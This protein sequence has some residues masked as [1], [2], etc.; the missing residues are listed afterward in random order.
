MIAQNARVANRRADPARQAFVVA[1]AFFCQWA[2]WPATAALPPVEFSAASVEIG[3][4]RATGLEVRLE[5][6]RELEARADQWRH[7]AIDRVFAAVALDGRLVDGQPPWKA[8]G[9]SGRVRTEGHEADLTLRRQEGGVEAELVIDMLP[10]ASLADI[11]GSTDLAGW[12]TRG[13][14]SARLRYAGKAERESA[15]TGTLRIGDL[16]FDSPDG[17]FAAEGLDFVVEG[18]WA[19]SDAPGADLRGTLA[20]G[21]L[22]IDSFYRDFSDGTLDFALQPRWRQGNLSLENIRLTDRQFLQ[23]RGRARIPSGGDLQNASITVDRLELAFPGAYLR[24][25][26]PAAATW[27]LD[28]LSV[29]GGMVWSGSWNAGVFRSGDLELRDLSVVDTTANRFA[30]TGLE[31][32]LRPGDHRFDSKLAW[33]GLLFGRI[34]LGAG[35]VAL[36][37]EPGAVA[38]RRPLELDVLGG[39]LR[40]QDFRIVFPGRSEDLE[41]EPDIRLRVGLEALDMKRLTAAMDWPSFEGK[42]SGEIPG[43]RFQDGVLEVDGGIRVNVFDGRIDLQ[44]LRIERPFGVLP[45][46]AGT[47]EIQDLD[48]EQLTRTF[49]FGRIAGRLDGHVHELRMLDWRPVAF[50]AWLGTPE[51]Q[52]EKNDI[53]RQAVNRLT[54][55]GGGGAT[56]A[57]TSPILRLFNSFSYRRLGLGCRLRNDVCEVRGIGEDD[58]SVLLLEGAGIPKITIRAFNRRVDWPQMVANLLA[59]STDSPETPGN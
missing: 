1:L 6:G 20:S 4:L 49:S 45:S 56:A 24:Y 48:L 14:V 46:L 2:A 9:L 33:R 13:T 16:A 7:Q 26:E 40:L 29:T 8:T 21:E 27:T 39:R 37:S 19:G 41:G 47:V 30:F 42:I 31:A 23:L 38:L 17:R 54:T 18:E 11:A 5:N 36:D 3:E 10:L 50:D 53:S 34:N 58:V 35:E 43:V 55:I 25:I 52:Q 15:L 22:L 44:D 59:I 28:G 57:L 32:T 12:L 51:R